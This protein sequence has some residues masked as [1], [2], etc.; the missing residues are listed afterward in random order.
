MIAQKQLLLGLML[1]TTALLITVSPSVSPAQD[2]SMCSTEAQALLK[3]NQQIQALGVVRQALEEVWKHIA[4][5]AARN[6]LVKEKASGYG[7]FEPRTNNVYKAGEVIRLYLEPVGFAQKKVKDH[8]A[9]GLEADFAVTDSAGKIIGGQEN[10]WRYETT[11]RNF[12]DD[13]FVNLDFTFTG[14]NPGAYEIKTVFRDL[15]STKTLTV[16]TPVRIE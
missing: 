14:L 1:L 13:F 11:S 9:V 2:L 5:Q 8:Y 10:F 4:F 12:L 7:Q 15:G 6:V 16:N 3:Q